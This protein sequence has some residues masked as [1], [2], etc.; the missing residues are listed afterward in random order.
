MSIA[1]HAEK[2]LVIGL[3]C[4]VPELIFAR[5]R[6][7][8]PVMRSLMESGIYGRMESCIPAITVPAWT[9]MMTSQDPGQLG[10]YGF[11]NRADYSYTAMT[12]ATARS[13][14][15]PRLWDILGARGKRVG[16]IGVP[17]TYPV[18]PVNG[19][20][21][22]C[23]LTPNAQSQFT[24]PP[25][26][27]DDIQSWI[28]DEFLVD[29]PDFRSP[30]KH[31]VLRDIY[32]LAEQRFTICRRLLE[33]NSYDFMI[34]VEMGVDRIHHGFWKDMDPAHPKH[35]ANSPFARAIHDYYQFI[36]RQIGQLL[37]IVDDNTAVL[38]ISDHGAKAMQGGFCLNEWLIQEGYLVLE[39]YPIRPIPLEQCRIDWK[40][41]RAWGSGG[42]YGRIFLNV[43]GREPQGVVS[44]AE[45]DRLRDELVAR[46]QALHDHQGQVMN[47][48]VF[49]PESIYQQVRG[50]APDLIVYFGDLDWR[51]VGSVGYSDIYTF[52]NDT[53]PDDANH[54]QFG[55][56]IFYDPKRKR[57]TPII[58]D[59]SIYDVAP[60]IL[61][62]LG[63][64]IP[65]SMI[66]R[67]KVW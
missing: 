34:M 56:Y 40:R 45:Y 33:R 52:E 29:V 50:I 10:I 23:F 2:L 17:P 48:R 62:Y 12:T 37:E 24:Y 63:Q 51:A 22:S 41:T 6:N 11:R 32:R 38:I 54:A 31:R 13:V 46:L 14:T 19:E 21:V 5:W 67:A 20:L 39:E 28:G 44:N 3:D 4:A 49:K 7:N 64:P 42:Y 55:M 26:L 60:T 27:R 8:L 57:S 16:V 66:G 25:A 59:I 30:D 18:R 58:E 43:A 9:C 1:T 61:T 53:G 35:V 47:N 65:E 15:V 36:D